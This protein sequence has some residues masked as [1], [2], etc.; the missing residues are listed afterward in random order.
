MAQHSAIKM[1]ASRVISQIFLILYSGKLSD[2]HCF[3][4]GLSWNM[5]VQ[6]QFNLILNVLSKLISYP[7][8]KGRTA[9]QPWNHETGLWQIQFL[10]VLTTWNANYRSAPFLTVCLCSSLAGSGQSSTPRFIFF[11]L[12]TQLMWNGLKMCPRWECMPPSIYLSS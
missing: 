9:P 7:S 12:V 2:W 1:L 8:G 10:N 6:V 5:S 3:R 11:T 4:W